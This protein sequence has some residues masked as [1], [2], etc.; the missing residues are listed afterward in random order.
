M[1]NHSYFYVQNSISKINIKLKK[2]YNVL[3]GYL[4]F[5]S[6]VSKMLIF[7]KCSYRLDLKEIK[8]QK[9]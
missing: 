1:R 5:Y 4:Y 9:E 7:F 6:C 2:L 3:I 8:P